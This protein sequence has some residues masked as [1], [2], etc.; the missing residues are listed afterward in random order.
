MNC[1]KEKRQALGLSQPALAKLLRDIDPRIDVGMVSRF[2]N[3][4]CLPTERVL[5]GLE[6]H[7]QASRSELYSGLELAAVCEDKA[8][9]SPK[10]EALAQV[11]PFGRENAISRAALA[12]KLNT[13]DRKMRAMISQARKEGLVIIN[14]QISGGGY[15]RSDDIEDLRRQLRQTHSRALSLLVQEKHI[16]QRIKAQEEN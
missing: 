6:K 7:L 11:I 15:Y 1:I 3:D 13:D 16:K 2:E 8:E 5:K 14:D 10:T 12:E 9:I 4:V